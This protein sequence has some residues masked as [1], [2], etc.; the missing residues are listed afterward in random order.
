VAAHLAGDVTEHIVSV[1][2]FDPEHRVG[3]GLGDLALHFD[4]FLFR[5]AAREGISTAQQAERLAAG[6]IGAVARSGLRE[7]Y[8]PR[9]GTGLGAREFAWSA[10]IAEIADPRPE[11]DLSLQR[12]V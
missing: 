4:L 1:V 9:D 2:Q 12:D 11:P 6:V 5:H 3:E 8:D 10:L 7:Y